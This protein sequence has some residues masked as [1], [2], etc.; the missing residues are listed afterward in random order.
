MY[1]KNI[2]AKAT[3]LMRSGY[4]KSDEIRKLIGLAQRVIEDN[5]LPYA[6]VRHQYYM[7][8][9]W[10]YAFI[11]EDV[12]ATDSFIYLAKEISSKIAT[13]DLE[14][15]DKTLVPCANIYFELQC[16][17]KSMK[18]LNEGIKICLEYEA[19]EV[20]N[21]RRKELCKYLCETANMTNHPERYRM[22]IERIASETEDSENRKKFSLYLEALCSI[23]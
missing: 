2:L 13:T 12:E 10:Y 14:V 17:E 3:I 20:Y 8:C 16:Y 4:G 18:L 1:A 7:V 19:L 21:R 5:T 23:S 22:L 11:C 6:D 15:I 9:G